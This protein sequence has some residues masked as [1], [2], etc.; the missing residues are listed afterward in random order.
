MTKKNA[1]K[2]DVEDG[3]PTMSAAGPQVWDKGM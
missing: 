2:D 1:S 3:D